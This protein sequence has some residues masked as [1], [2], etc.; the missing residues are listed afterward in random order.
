MALRFDA[1]MPVSAISRVFGEIFDLPFSPG[2]LSQMFERNVAKLKPATPEV[3]GRVLQEP[4]IIVDE[5]GWWQDGKRAWLS[6]AVAPEMSFFQIAMHRDR[7]AFETMVPT[8]Y[9]GSSLRTPTASTTTFLRPATHSAGR[10]RS[11]PSRRCS[12]SAAPPSTTRSSRS[13]P[14]SRLDRQR[15]RYLLYLDDK[16]VP[17]TTNPVE[18]DLRG[19]IPVRKLSFGTRNLR[20][21]LQWAHG[22]SIAK[23]L[24]KQRKHLVSY[25]PKALAAVELGA[26]LPSVFASPL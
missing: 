15:I 2:G 12:S 24:K 3:H 6:T 10:I 23:T 14:A 8:W 20:G 13:V 22:V 17:L 5:T 11:R 26:R 21:S 9:P 16:T 7:A 4:V 1:G 19:G 25:I 18:R